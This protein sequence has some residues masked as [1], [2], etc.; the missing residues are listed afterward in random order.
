MDDG[1]WKSSGP[2]FDF[3][4]GENVAFRW[5]YSVAYSFNSTRSRL[6]QREMLIIFPLLVHRLIDCLID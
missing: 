4:N 3:S 6:V 2:G 1:K 5:I